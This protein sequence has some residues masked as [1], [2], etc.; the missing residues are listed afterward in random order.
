MQD[1]LQEIRDQDRYRLVLW[2]PVGFAFGA[3]TTCSVRADDPA[4]ALGDP[5]IS[6]FGHVASL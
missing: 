2:L 4:L 6:D 3:G 1:R 5:H